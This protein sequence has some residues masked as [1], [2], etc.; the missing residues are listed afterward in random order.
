V[1]Q[2]VIDLQHVAGDVRRGGGRI[3]SLAREDAIRSTRQN[4]EAACFACFAH[5]MRARD[6]NALA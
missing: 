6:E 1:E 2:R 4:N 5:F 3:A